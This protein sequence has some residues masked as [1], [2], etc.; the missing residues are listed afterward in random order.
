MANNRTPI[1]IYDIGAQPEGTPRWKELIQ[2][3]AVNFVEFE[4]ENPRPGQLPYFLGD[5]QERTFYQTRYFGCSSLLEPDPEVINR[6]MGMNCGL[7]GGNFTVVGQKTVTTTRLDDIPDLPQPDLVKIDT[8]GAEL[9]ILE[10]GMK[11]I[12]QALVIEA[13][14]DFVRLYKNQPLFSHV[15][16]FLR[17]HGFE[18]HRFEEIAGRCFTPYLLTNNPFKGTSQFVFA[19]AVYV[20]NLTTPQDLQD[21]ELIRLAQIMHY[22]YGSHDLCAHLYSEYDHRH[23]SHWADQYRQR[24]R[25]SPDHFITIRDH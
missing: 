18:L 5:G 13:E 3:E 10:H 24:L 23:A 22:V 19:D 9:M 20:R 2:H 12:G 25:P 8:Q 17:Q 21:A 15:D 6:F 4:P 14:V 7:P 1:C 16:C 11:T